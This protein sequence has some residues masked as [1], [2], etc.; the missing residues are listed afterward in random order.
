MP[1]W[2]SLLALP[3]VLGLLHA[4]MPRMRRRPLGFFAMQP[5]VDGTS[6]VAPPSTTKWPDGFSS[7]SHRLVLQRVA[8]IPGFEALSASLKSKD[9][10]AAHEALL[11]LIDAHDDAALKT[12]VQAQQQQ[13]SQELAPTDATA[14][15]SAKRQRSS[16]RGAAVAAVDN[17]SGDGMKSSTDSA[18]NS[19][20][21]KQTAPQQLSFPLGEA[22]LHWMVAASAQFSY[23][24]IKQKSWHERGNSSQTAATTSA[25]ALACSL[26]QT[27]VKL[28]ARIRALGV[29]P[30]ETTYYHCLHALRR[31][32]EV[33]KVGPVFRTLID[34]RAHERDLAQASDAAAAAASEKPAVTPTSDPLATTIQADAQ[35]AS[36]KEGA[37][38]SATAAGAATPPFL[39]SS[40]WG[41]AISCEASAGNTEAALTLL[42]R[43]AVENGD[44]YQIPPDHYDHLFLRYGGVGEG[45]NSIAQQWR[46]T[47]SILSNYVM[48]CPY[49]CFPASFSL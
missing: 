1:K 6:A 30:S 44:S 39:R 46:L 45:V 23:A 4:D 24:N 13:P 3:T 17:V 7:E 31:L 49:F 32:G 16:A 34:V 41:L 27:S 21:N 36:W 18:G 12:W 35:D 29:L 19:Q 8:E 40:L 2:F 15:I 25:P 37:V 43:S 10:A 5:A 42:E 48:N 38:N 47:F 28:L 9:A 22:E 26:G 33:D 20:S 11:A 14:K